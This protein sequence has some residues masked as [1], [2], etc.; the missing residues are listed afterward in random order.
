MSNIS[1]EL[2]CA[3]PSQ[4]GMWFVD[5]LKVGKQTQMAFT[6]LITVR[7][8]VTYLLITRLS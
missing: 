8:E 5:C 2:A 4:E 6:V 1:F 7:Q 3:A